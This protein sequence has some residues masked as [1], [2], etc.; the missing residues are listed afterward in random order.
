[1]GF[2]Y[3]ESNPEL[4]MNQKMQSQW[5]DFDAKHHKTRRAFIK[6]LK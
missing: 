4:E 5:G 3:A 6:H 1:M 2:V